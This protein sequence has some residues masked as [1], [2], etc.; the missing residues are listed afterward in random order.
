MKKIFHWFLNIGWR[1]SGPR[2]K[3]LFLSSHLPT[4]EMDYPGLKCRVLSYPQFRLSKPMRNEPHTVE[5]IERV[6][7]GEVLYD[8]GASV[9]P[10]ALIAGKRGC[11]VYAFEP[12]PASFASLLDNIQLNHLETEVHPLN[13]ALGER[14][15]FHPFSYRSLSAG[16][17]LHGGLSENDINAADA[18]GNGFS[19]LLY[20]WRLDDLQRATGIPLPDHVKMDI[21]GYELP[22]LRG[23]RQ[24]IA[25]C[26][27]AQVEVREYTA[28]SVVAFFSEL[29]FRVER[30]IMRIK[31]GKKQ[32]NAWVKDIQ[33]QKITP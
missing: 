16:E 3:A 23:G 7:Q 26:K 8:I 15:E 2:Y 11:R 18:N 6:R 14:T 24:T 29:G 10:Y 28:D 19:H 27:T 25:H 21:D 33:F 1:L 30:E 4:T 31:K 32:K 17:T 5:W 12:T 22:A 20:S 9:G 13:V